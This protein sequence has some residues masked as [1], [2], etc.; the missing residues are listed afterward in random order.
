MNDTPRLVVGIDPSCACTGWAVLDASSGSMMGTLREKGSHKPGEGTL[1]ER[2]AETATDVR[3]H[4]LGLRDLLALV[5][6]EFP[7]KSERS[8]SA[9]FGRRSI[10]TLPNYGICVGAVYEACRQ[11][12]DC[13]ILTPASDEWTGG[14]IP[15]TVGDDYKIGR[16]RYAS[17][18]YGLADGALGPKTYAG[19]VADAILLARWGLF[20]LGGK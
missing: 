4:L 6:V 1:A 16:V 14:D 7:A 2:V 8:P 20:R 12:C 11:S 10:L 13:P 9:E 5:V 18:L 17:S 3:A 15:S 19:N